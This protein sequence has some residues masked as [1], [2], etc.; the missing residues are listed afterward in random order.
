MSDEMKQRIMH[1]TLPI[2]AE[3]K[4]FGSDT[5]GEW[6]SNHKVGNNIALS[7]NTKDK[8]EADRLFN[9][10]AN[11]GSITMPIADTFWG[12][13]FGMVTDKFGI[14]WQVNCELGSPQ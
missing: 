7:I 8:A 3:T 10:L 11:G 14:N 5:G 12:A 2:S 9:A 13:Y 6:A 1:I 4:L